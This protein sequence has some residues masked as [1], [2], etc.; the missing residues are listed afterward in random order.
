MVEFVVVLHPSMLSVFKGGNGTGSVKSLAPNT[1]IDCG[2]GCEEAQAGFEEGQ[3]IE[4]QATAGSG[5]TF[6]GWI[7]CRHVT[8][9]TCQVKLGSSQVE[10]TA[11]FLTEGVVGET[12]VLSEFDGTHEPA[13]NPCGGRGGVQISTAS[14]TKYVCDG[15]IGKDGETPTITTFAGNQHG[16]STGGLEVKLGVSITY[17]CNGA[18]GLAGTAGVQGSRGEPGVSGANGAQGAQGLAGTA[19]AVGPSGPQGKEGPAGPAGKV[20]CSVTQK[21]KQKAKA[22]C[23]V[24]YTGQAKTSSTHRAVRWT[25]VRGGHVVAHG[26]SRNTP[27]IRLGA[28]RHGTYTLYLQGQRQGTV[29]HVH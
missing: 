2:A 21:G 18:K 11:V 28:L 26:A 3:S 27:K 24:K 16:C 22:I 1:G 5:S 17:V 29:I 25:L 19:G 23:T 13:G 12:P 14:A 4:L 20:T 9:T 7:G 10:V 15:T 8:A 6:A